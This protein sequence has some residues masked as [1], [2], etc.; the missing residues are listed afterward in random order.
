M[1]RR[2]GNGLL[3]VEIDTETH[4]LRVTRQSSRSTRSKMIR[5]SASNGLLIRS[6]GSPEYRHTE[7]IL[8]IRGEC[9]GDDDSW[10][11]LPVPRADFE[12]AV[13]AI[14]AA[15]KE[16]CA[17]SLVCSDTDGD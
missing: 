7:G 9:E 14:E 10:A 6:V 16:Y 13:D 11:R 2:T 5:F 8:F 1:I 12:W 4:K 17:K 3:E 15:V